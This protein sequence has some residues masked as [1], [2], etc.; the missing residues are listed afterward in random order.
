[1]KLNLDVEIARLCAFA[2]VVTAHANSLE[3][4]R[5]HQDVGFFLDELCRFSV[6][7]FFLVSGFF[8]RPSQI[9]DPVSYLKKLFPKIAIPFVLWAAIYLSLDA[10]QLLYSSP[11]P[12]TW[13]S[14]ITTPWSGGIAF[15]LWFLPGLFIGTGIGMALVKH[16]GLNRA[17]IVVFVLFLIGAFLGTY[18]RPLG[19]TL[20]L[21]TYRNG[22]FF[23]PIFLVS[24]YYLKTLP[25][26]PGLPVFAVMAVLGWALNLV[27][28][29]YVFRGYPN[30]HDLSL[31]TLPFG[32][33][34]FG[35]LLHLKSSSQA[36][37]AW[38]R[39]VFGAYLVHVLILKL[40]IEYFA[41][42]SNL[43]LT[44]LL[45]ALAILLSLM[46]SRAAKMNR[47][48]QYLVP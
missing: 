18:L 41:S 32:I 7:L 25:K 38:G 10:T 16:L 33:G 44:L 23:S 13:R 45:I 39:D 14:Y 42:P 11:E 35:M 34:V 1:M 31:G 46:F 48:T 36:F 9:D 12:R 2:C 47:W 20:P 8:W 30:G 29:I 22:I 26:L 6:Q 43:P 21:S 5:Q 37:A 28:G 40:F 27:E 4:F 17:M 24:G 15:H 3:M 19:V